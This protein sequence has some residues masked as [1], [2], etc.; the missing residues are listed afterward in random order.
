MVE[1]LA[2]GGTRNKSL[3]VGRTTSK[4]LEGLAS[5]T[6]RDFGLEVPFPISVIFWAVRSWEK[7]DQDIPDFAAPAGP[8]RGVPG[9]RGG[10]GWISFIIL[11][12]NNTILMPYNHLS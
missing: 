4:C 6:A 1:I 8:P 12:G 7:L 10:A 3:H 2:R 5:N 9:W 11:M